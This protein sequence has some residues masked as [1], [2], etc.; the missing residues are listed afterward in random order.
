MNLSLDNPYGE[1]TIP[2]AKLRTSEDTST[3]IANPLVVDTSLYSTQA[4]HN[5]ALNPYGSFKPPGDES[6]QGA[7]ESR[8]GSA[9]N[10]PPYEAQAA[11][12]VKEDPEEVGR[13][14]ACCRR[15]RKK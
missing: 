1:V 14:N 8:D 2:R 3:V 7:P 5:S 12:T 6:A 11:Y 15:C 10:P 9:Q 13:C 4:R